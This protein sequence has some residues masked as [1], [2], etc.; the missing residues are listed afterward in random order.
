MRGPPYDVTQVKM[1]KVM[2]E[3][4]FETVRYASRR[5]TW[6]RF[7]KEEG[8]PRCCN[9]GAFRE[10]QHAAVQVGEEET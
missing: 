3:L 5:M 8:C 7:G 10:S 6:P 4:L 9:D 1:R 2:A